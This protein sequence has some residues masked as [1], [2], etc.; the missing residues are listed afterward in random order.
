[1]SVRLDN[2]S[3]EGP[4]QCA[5]Q[6]L[7]RSPIGAVE[8]CSCGA[9]HLS[10]GALSLRLDAAVLRAIVVMSHEALGR[11]DGPSVGP[12]ARGSA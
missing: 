10:I 5:R 9:L 6:L 3:G 12:R 2:V 4:A 7:A 1:M 8:R 11:L